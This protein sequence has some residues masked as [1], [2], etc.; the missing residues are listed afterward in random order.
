[1]INLDVFGGTLVKFASRFFVAKNFKKKFV[2]TSGR[3]PTYMLES[4]WSLQIT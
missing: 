1:M 4:H 2:K 3:T